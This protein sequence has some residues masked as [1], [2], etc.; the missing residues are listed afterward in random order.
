M[1]T[2]WPEYS[3]SIPW[4]GTVAIV[5]RSGAR[6]RP[7]GGPRIT[8]TGDDA[9]T[10]LRLGGRHR[11]ERGST[12]PCSPTSSSTVRSAGA[13]SAPCSSSPRRSVAASADDLGHPRL[14]LPRLRL[15]HLQERARGRRPLA[16]R[17][18]AEP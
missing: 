7:R 5:V 12:W 4:Q 2:S 8:A 6:R 9:P 16:A 14:A 3:P 18:G 10:T 15:E 17:V 1:L 13:P 11:H